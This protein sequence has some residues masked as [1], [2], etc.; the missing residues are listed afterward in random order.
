VAV[1]NPSQAAFTAYSHTEAANVCTVLGIDASPNGPW[2]P[3][4]AKYIRCNGLTEIRQ[5]ASETA[6]TMQKAHSSVGPKFISD[7]WAYAVQAA[8]G[9]WARSRELYL[10]LGLYEHSLRGKVVGLVTHHLGAGWWAI[11]P[12][13]YMPVGEWEY[14]LASNS[15]VRAQRP[16]PAV[17]VPP[18]R[19]IGTA[20]DFVDILTLKEL[21]SIVQFLKGALFDH[22]LMDANGRPF[23][24]SYLES[25]HKHIE[26]ARN[27]VMHARA[28]PKSAYPRISTTLETLLV[29]LEFD[30]KKTLTNI[31]SASP[32]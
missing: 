3:K 30:V 10:R 26:N 21:H 28:I 1:P 8:N 27:D 25:A 2:V 17:P 22:V 13:G 29:A 9:R 4:V 20:G 12:P 18:M 14:M 32:V 31:G 5:A 19:A 15:K 16:T 7:P 24:R 11:S 6:L 23:T